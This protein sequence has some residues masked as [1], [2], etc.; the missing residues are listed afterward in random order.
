MNE[1]CQS[2]FVL[3]IAG[4]GT[5][6]LEAARK[7]YQI[8]SKQKNHALDQPS[9]SA[10]LWLRI[11]MGILQMVAATV[12]DD[13]SI[14][15]QLE[16]LR[17]YTV[18]ESNLYLFVLNNCNTRVPGHEAKDTHVYIPNISVYPVTGPTSF[19]CVSLVTIDTST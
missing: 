12:M 3:N 11:K 1:L 13:M 2:L 6:T 8:V 16:L 19:R 15:I 9:N 5:H 7:I 14:N 18:P 10:T 4:I 17:K